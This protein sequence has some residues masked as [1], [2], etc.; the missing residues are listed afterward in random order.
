MNPCAWFHL[1]LL[2]TLVEERAGERR[3]LFLAGRF[4]RREFLIH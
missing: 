3:L 1:P 2:H 4:M